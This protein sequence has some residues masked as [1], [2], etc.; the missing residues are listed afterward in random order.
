MR[1]NPRRLM[2]SPRWKVGY[3]LAFTHATVSVGSILLTEMLLLGV[4][5][6]SQSGSITWGWHIVIAVSISAVIG[7]LLGALF[8]QLLTRRLRRMRD[9]SQAWLRGNL[10]LRI[11]DLHS[12]DIRQFADQLDALAEQL[13][14]D[15]EDLAVLRER[16]A[17]LT[18]QV[19]ALA[20][21]EERNRLARE[22]HDSVKQ[23]LFSLAMTASAIRTHFEAL[24]RTPEGVTP[25]TGATLGDM[26]C[27]I[28][29]G[30]Q[31]AQRETTRLIEDLRPGSLQEQGLAA[32]LNDYTLLVGAQE[33]LLIYLEVIGDDRRLP[34]SVSEALYRVVQEALH[35]IARHARATRVDVHL[36]CDV[37]RVKLTIEDNGV[38]FDTTRRS[39]GLGLVNMQERM[40]NVGG[41]LSLESQVGVGT[42]VLAEAELPYASATL[43]SLTGTAITAH[44]P[45]PSP[46][47]WAWLGAKLVIPVGQ[48]WPWLP[49]DLPHLRKP[50]LEP[51]ATPLSYHRLPGFLGLGRAYTVTFNEHREPLAR[52]HHSISG[53]EWEDASASWALRR[54]RGVSGRMVLTRN[55]QP[56]S[57]LQYQGRQMNT[58]SEIIFDNRGYRLAYTKGESGC[59]FTL[60]DEAGQDLLC[61]KNDGGNQI[62]L[63]HALPLPLLVMTT[64]RIIDELAVA[65]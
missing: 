45:N 12:D 19:R 18:D 60:S 31:R 26:V 13:E 25:F 65:Q 44:R 54:V 15:E 47:N 20:V 35:N 32:A 38:G 63:Y 10:A 43:P 23:H 33:H 55:K 53:Y 39:P 11:N 16:N 21:V 34:S 28:E 57:A 59:A 3:I 30:A 8:S 51:E 56:L 17:R 4:L 2:R 29:A 49:A 41:R 42:T 40:L 37:E 7:L 62:M 36:R 6:L 46:D 52:I 61:F 50:L 64:A 58:W 14:K 22:L 24:E 48:T 5:V 27:E 1:N 9:I